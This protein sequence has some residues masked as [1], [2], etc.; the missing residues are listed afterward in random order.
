MSDASDATH[1]GA[2]GEM[3]CLKYRRQHASSFASAQ[4][5]STFEVTRGTP[6]AW[7]SRS[8]ARPCR[9]RCA[10]WIT[11][12]PMEGPS[13]TPRN[14]YNVARRVGANRRCPA[15]GLVGASPALNN[16]GKRSAALQS[17]KIDTAP[18]RFR[19]AAMGSR[20]SAANDKPM[21]STTAGSQRQ[22]GLQP[23]YPGRPFNASE[24]LSHS[25]A[26]PMEPG[27]THTSLH[28]S[29]AWLWANRV[30]DH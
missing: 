5:T 23:T 19:H 21:D 2:L 16:A 22:D 6:A 9:S 8:I 29:G 12:G 20:T 3:W 24:N 7:H 14:G 28:F 13:R 30:N 27:G 17:R 15:C 18:R 25:S 26:A 4:H 10:R 11:T 1:L